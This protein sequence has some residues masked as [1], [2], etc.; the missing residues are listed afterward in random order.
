MKNILAENMRRFGTKNLNE[1]LNDYVSIDTNK[2]VQDLGVV[3]DE[4]Q[5]DRARAGRQDVSGIPLLTRKDNFVRSI[6]DRNNNSSW[7]GWLNSQFK[8]V[9][10]KGPV[11]GQPQ[12]QTI[13]VAEKDVAT[14]AQEYTDQLGG[15]KLTDA[16]KMSIA[17][18]LVP[19][20]IKK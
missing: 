15:G 9:N 2:L 11:A 8:T 10:V 17:S 20:T 14:L 6:A 5:Q 13:S 7:P 3:Y 19:N 18:V 4:I 1:N 16:V 12:T